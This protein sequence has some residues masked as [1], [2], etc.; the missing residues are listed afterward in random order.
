MPQ[1]GEMLRELREERRP[2]ELAALR[3]AAGAEQRS[4]HVPVAT[5]VVELGEAEA[6]GGEQEA[7]ACRAVG[8]RCGDLRDE[9]LV[10]PA[11]GDHGVDPRLEEHVDAA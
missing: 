2:G 11:A 7:V 4:E 3:P 6:D 1:F 9:L 10:R 8:D 5:R